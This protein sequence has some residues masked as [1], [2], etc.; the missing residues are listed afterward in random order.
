LI[1]ARRHTC[2]KSFIRRHKKSRPRA[3]FF[4]YLQLV[5]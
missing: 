4:E 3:G 2:L 1:P 5:Q